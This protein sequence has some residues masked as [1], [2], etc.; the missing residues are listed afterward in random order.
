MTILFVPSKSTK[1]YEND[2][3]CM[4]FPLS[5]SLRPLRLSF[6]L[7]FFVHNDGDNFR[8]NSKL[9]REEIRKKTK[10]TQCLGDKRL[11]S[12]WFSLTLYTLVLRKTVKSEQLWKLCIASVICCE[13]PS[14]S[15]I[16]AHVTF[17]RSWGGR[18]RVDK[19]WKLSRDYHL[20]SLASILFNFHSFSIPPFT[21]K[22]VR[23]R[24]IM[25][26]E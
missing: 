13:S 1:D 24:T 18:L 5:T 25:K 15:L 17:F 6:I 9:E 7:Y 21:G 16:F 14:F 23:S 19:L 12:L 20:R 8:T 3:R 22:P 10:H 11:H 2:L 4:E 26:N